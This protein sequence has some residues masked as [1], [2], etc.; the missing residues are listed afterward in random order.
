MLRSLP[1]RTKNLWKRFLG[2]R[3]L[4][5]QQQDIL[6]YH[7]SFED[8]FGSL[9]ATLL[10]MFDRIRS[11][12]GVQADA[13]RTTVIHECDLTQNV[14]TKQ[15]ET[16]RAAVSEQCGLT[17]A[18]VSEQSAL[19][20][21]AIAE[22]AELTRTT[23]INVIQTHLDSIG[24]DAW[25]LQELEGLLRY[26]R[27][28]DYLAAIQSGALEVPELETQHPVA[29]SSIDTLYPRGCKNDNSI[30]LRFNRKLNKWIGNNTR[31]KILDLG[32]AGGGMVR[33]FLD[34]G[35]FAVGLEGS[36]YPLINQIGE[37]PTISRHLFTCDITKPFRLSDSLTG[38]AL[39]FDV[40]TGWEVMAHIAEESL[41]ALLANISRHL[42]PGGHLIFSIATFLDWDTRTGIKWH[43]T[44]KPEDWWI[45]VFRSAGFGVSPEHPFTMGDYVRGSGH[46]RGDW[47]E[48]SNP[49]FHLVLH[50]L[51]DAKMVIP[52]ETAA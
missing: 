22:Q 38:E 17:R 32:C 7:L 25:R 10:S 26:Q 34:D 15:A 21:A 36:D 40:I 27:R 46:C 2:V 31:L 5:S 1:R 19:T 50:R 23:L 13:T 41:P 33:S 45:N 18:A 29:V 9:P 8:R 52:S 30:C 44:V 47:P 3:G 4:A 37:W 12:I 11:S 6:R 39:L 35:H 51:C 14:I 24:L 42:A 16:T 20:R 43:V 48:G 28:R 49:G